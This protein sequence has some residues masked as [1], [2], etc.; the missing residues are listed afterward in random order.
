M[1]SMVRDSCANQ[2]T[3]L[4]ASRKARMNLESIRKALRMQLQ[5]H[6]KTAETESVR[7]EFGPPAGRRACIRASRRLRTV[8]A[9]TM[10]GSNRMERRA[11]RAR[12]PDPIP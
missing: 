5:F 4:P 1:I 3:R 8:A 10:V 7:H 2:T 6:E 11:Y 9:A 12:D